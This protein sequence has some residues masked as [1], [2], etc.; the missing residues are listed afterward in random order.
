[1]A[2]LLQLLANG[3]TQGAI[4][5]ILAIGFGL[6]LR[7]LRIFHV[8]Y[9][10][11][12][13]VASY[14]LYALET[15]FVLPIWL[16]M[17]ASIAISAAVGYLLERLFYRPF[18]RRNASPGVVLVASLGL[19]V[20]V[21]NTIVILFG[22][23]TKTI[24][25]GSQPTFTLGELTLTDIQL[26]QFLVGAVFVVSSWMVV[27]R[28][29]L[30]RAIWALGDEPQLVAVLGL[31]LWR[32]RETV[33]TLSGVGVGV[34]ACLTS[35]DLGMDPHVGM[36]YLLVTAVAVIIGG[37]DSFAGWILGAVG[38]ALLRS[39]VVWQISSQW[40]SLVTFLLL[41]AILAFRPRGILG[42]RRRI[43]ERV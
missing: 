41:I 4:Y 20:I 19:S 8:A 21:E 22:N 11:H 42:T 43:E 12:F 30:F 6:V 34:A 16:A 9:G 23:D 7:T 39:I 29:R 18:Y 14:V 40:V 1:M 3:M 15:R 5:A 31:P 35:V 25:R 10:A 17:A 2:L 24:L 26:V 13:V 32:L 33:L 27:R 37:I 38:L 36:H 28:L